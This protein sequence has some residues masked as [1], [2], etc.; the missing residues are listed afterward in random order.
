MICCPS[1]VKQCPFK[2][3]YYS[4]FDRECLAL[5]T[6]NTS[7]GADVVVDVVVVV[8]VLLGCSLC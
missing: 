2:K 5:N 7:A 1:P 3:T 6:Y 8:V 4:I